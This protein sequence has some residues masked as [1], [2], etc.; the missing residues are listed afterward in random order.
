MAHV[1]S[2][3]FAA[4]VCA[5]F[6]VPPLTTTAAPLGQ[7]LPSVFY[8]HPNDSAFY[9]IAHKAGTDKQLDHNYDV[10]YSK[11]FEVD[12]RRMM[13]LKVLEIGLGCDMVYGPGRSATLWRHYF[14]SSNIWFAE[15]NGQCVEAHQ[16]QLASMGIKVVVGDQRH[17]PTLQSWVNTT[18]GAFDVIIDDGGH[19]NFQQFNSFMVLFLH[20]LKPGG[21][22]LIEDLQ[23][24][25]TGH[26]VDGD[27]RHNMDAVLADWAMALLNS[28]GRFQAGNH[29]QRFPMPPGIRTIEF[30]PEIAAIV[31]C[32]DDDDQCNYYPTDNTLMAYSHEDEITSALCPVRPQ[33]LGTELSCHLL[34]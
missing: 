8:S 6:L 22:Y 16:A 30:G 18:G 26:W 23:A 29:H 2:C 28:G 31:K 3:L 10:L 7:T 9:R 12:N 24:A 15:F 1:L 5:F 11:Y 17:I 20:A 32:F 21:V 4:F 27:L 25:A 33:P 34:W 13:S 14:P 19:T